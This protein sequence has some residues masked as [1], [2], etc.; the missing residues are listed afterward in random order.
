MKRRE[1]DGSSL[2]QSSQNDIKDEEDAEAADDALCSILDEFLPPRGR[3]FEYPDTPA[4][5]DSGDSSSELDQRTQS[6]Q[7]ERGVS[8]PAVAILEENQGALELGREILPTRGDTKADWGIKIEYPGVHF[9]GEHSNPTGSLALAFQ[10]TRYPSPPFHE[11][12]SNPTGSLALIF[13][14]L[15]SP[16]LCPQPYTDEEPKA[17][18]SPGDTEDDMS[19]FHG[20]LPEELLLFYKELDEVMEESGG[21]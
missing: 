12:C 13:Q 10:G 21:I 6:P 9:H 16:G 15:S 7:E 18:P 1:V 11:A 20:F 19:D 17:V 8:E 3:T 14:A 2:L 5:S 4:T